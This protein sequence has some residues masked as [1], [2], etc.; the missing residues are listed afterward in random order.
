MDYLAFT[1][2]RT[3]FLRYFYAEAAAP[4]HEIRRK[5]EAYEE[6]FECPP[7]YEDAEP[8]FLSEWQ[9]AADALDVLGQSV[10]SLLAQTLKLYIEH[11]IDEVRR[12]AG[13]DQLTKLGIGLPT[14]P[15]YKSAF[16]KG[17]LAGYRAYSDRLGTDWAQS[18]VDLAVLEQLIL[19]RNSV[20]HSADITSVRVRQTKADTDR[21]PNGFFADAFDIKLNDSMKPGSGF[22]LPPRLDM[23]GD[24]LARALQAVDDLCSWLDS[25]HPLRPSS[26]GS[27]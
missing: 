14:D 12:R 1:R 13:D 10:A 20:Q 2:M 4:F 25:S 18:P 7:G 5:I 27:S 3:R 17:W 11:W 9:D 26:R 19:A 8:P 21:Y 16:K 24:K 23:S 15:A 22:L 6:P